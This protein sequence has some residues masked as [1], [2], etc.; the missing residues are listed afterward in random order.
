MESEIKRIYSV[1]VIT[2]LALQFI[3]INILFL[4]IHRNEACGLDEGTQHT[5][6]DL[7]TESDGQMEFGTLKCI[8]NLQLINKFENN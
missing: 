5:S 2:K 4:N 8:L 3:L 1:N 6:Y 7:N